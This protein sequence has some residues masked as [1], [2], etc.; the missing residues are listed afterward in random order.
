MSGIV[1]AVGKLWRILTRGGEAVVI[2]NELGKAVVKDGKDK[3]TDSS[4]P[5]VKP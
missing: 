4:K 2:A 1:K 5:E 3:K